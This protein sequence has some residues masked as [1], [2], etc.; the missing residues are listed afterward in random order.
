LKTTGIILLL[1]FFLTTLQL[2]AQEEIR[3]KYSPRSEKHRN[4]IDEMGRKQ[5]L[6]KYYTQGGI[7]YLEISFQNDVKHG[8]YF[9]RSTATGILIEEANFFNGKRDGE[10]KKYSSKGLLMLEGFYTSGVKTGKWTAYYPFNGEKK[11]EGAYE[12]GKRTGT[13]VY[14]SSKGKLR[15]EG[16]YTEGLRE[17]S[18]K[19]YNSDGSLAE[20][21]KYVKG[22]SI[23]SAAPE[24]PKKSKGFKLAPKKEEPKTT[25]GGT[26]GN[27]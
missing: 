24:K 3:P 15:V 18:W 7:L 2:S 4:K 22:V 8:Q 25:P 9:R 6:W 5:G 21:K 12:A 10:Y 26:P 16:E 23:E 17:G 1:T 14:Y 20:E 19:F 13:W 11:S 27:Q